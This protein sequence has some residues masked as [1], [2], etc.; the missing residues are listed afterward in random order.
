MLFERMSKFVDVLPIA[1][2]S[3]DV[4][5]IPIM[6]S[7][8]GRP[9]MIVNVLPFRFMSGADGGDMLSAMD[10]LR[11]IDVTHLSPFFLT[12]R[13]GTNGHRAGQ[14]RIPWSSC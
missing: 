13:P 10:L 1:M 9:D 5:H 12:R 8:M 7:L 4:R 6:R 2:S 3:Y 11:D 14:A